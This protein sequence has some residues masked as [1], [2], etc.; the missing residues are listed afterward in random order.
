MTSTISYFV[1]SN[2]IQLPD[3]SIFGAETKE[4]FRTVSETGIS[5]ILVYEV[6][7][8]DLVNVFGSGIRV[9]WK[10]MKKALD[11]RISYQIGIGNKVLRGGEEIA[12]I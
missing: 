7:G 5:G 2:G 1:N 6:I 8:S 9:S 12:E 11:E 3:G 4:M 10:E